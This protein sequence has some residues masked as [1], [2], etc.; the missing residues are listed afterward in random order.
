VYVNLG[1][2][3]PARCKDPAQDSR[4]ATHIIRKCVKFQSHPNLRK[5]KTSLYEQIVESP[6][7]TLQEQR[8]S[9]ERDEV[10]SVL[11][12]DHLRTPCANDSNISH[13]LT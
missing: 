4:Y 13:G 3:Y 11:M 1:Q 6:I 12:E 10:V 2:S 8:Q 7:N 9:R 5:G